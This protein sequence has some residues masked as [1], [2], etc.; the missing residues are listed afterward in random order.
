MARQCHFVIRFPRQS[1]TRS[2]AVWAA[3][4]QERVVTLEVT[5]KARA[6]VA[7]HHLPTRLRVRLIK[8]VLASGEVEVLGTDLLDAQTYPAAE[9]KA[10]YG[11]RWQHETYHDRIKNIFEVERFSGKS[12]QAIKQDFYGVVFLATLESI[13][14]KPAQAVL[15][16]QGEVRECRYAPQVNRAVVT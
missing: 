2:V 16:T 6:Y 11:W 12:V 4:A 14:S 3:P 5:S 10:V 7:E 9:F 13:L 1:F 8:V 15:T